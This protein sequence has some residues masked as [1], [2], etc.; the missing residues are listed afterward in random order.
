MS[1]EASFKVSEPG[2][3][4]NV[5]SEFCLEEI[6]HF[7]SF[8]CAQVNSY[9]VS[10]SCGDN[11]P[12]ILLSV[13]RFSQLTSFGWETIGLSSQQEQYLIPLSLI[14]YS[15]LTPTASESRSLL[16]KIKSQVIKFFPETIIFLCFKP[17]ETFPC[18]IWH[19]LWCVSQT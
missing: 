5:L 3:R 15:S 6:P 2:L 4:C 11:I 10:M 12:Q 13:A 1:L 18:R 14:M 9:D 16:F 7:D 8:M 19:P 17:Y